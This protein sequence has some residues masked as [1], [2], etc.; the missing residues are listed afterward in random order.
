MQKQQ[1]YNQIPTILARE[2]PVIL[3][4]FHLTKNEQLLD[5]NIFKFDYHIYSNNFI[6]PYSLYLSLKENP[7]CTHII[8]EDFLKTLDKEYLDIIESAISTMDSGMPWKVVYHHYPSFLFEGKIVLCTRLNEAK[9]RKQ[10][11]LDFLSSC[12]F[13]I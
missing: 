7:T 8:K 9:I 1:H 2:T 11:Q 13:F 4:Q 12:S 10:K 5:K 3:T 6:Q